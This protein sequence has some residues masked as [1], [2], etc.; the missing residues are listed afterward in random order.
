MAASLVDNGASWTLTMTHPVRGQAVVTLMKGMGSTGGSV[1][2]GGA[3]AIPL[4]S[5][6]QGIQ[7][8][9]ER[10]VWDAAFLFRDGFETVAP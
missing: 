8:T 6:V 2:I 7:V 1:A 4:R 5:D 3:P 9:R 10:P